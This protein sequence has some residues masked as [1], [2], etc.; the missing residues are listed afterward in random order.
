MGKRIFLAGVLTLLASMAFA[1][2]AISLEPE[3]APAAAPE[4]TAPAP[5][6]PPAPSAPAPSASVPPVIVQPASPKVEVAF[7]SKL[8]LYIVPAA[9][10]EVC[11]TLE[12][13]FGE[14]QTDCRMKPI[15][16]RAE[17]PVLR[18]LCITRYGRR[19]C[20]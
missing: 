13:G 3:A 19:T 14:I 2:H 16:I 20:Y 4:A 1:Q 8:D 11:T 5:D 12:L 15:P 9:T 18:G 7:P 10:R 6:V 17:N